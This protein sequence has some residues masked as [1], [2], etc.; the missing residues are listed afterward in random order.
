MVWHIAKRELY[1]NLNSLRFAVAIL[2][3]F[4][5]MLTNAVVHLREHPARVQRYHDA[6]RKA[7]DGVTG[8][9][10]SGLYE[11]ARKGP[12][13]FN[14][15]PAPLRFCAEGGER[16]FATH[17]ESAYSRWGW[18]EGGLESFWIVT[19]PSATPTMRSVRTAVT[20]VDWGFIIG[21]VLSLLALLFTFDAIAGERESGTLR[22]MLANPVPRHA[23]LI[24][25]FLGALISIGI[26][27]TLAVFVNLLVLSTSSDIHLGLEA[28]Q[29]L[30]IIFGVALLYVSLFLA[31]GLLV[32]ARV[33]SSAISLVILLLIWSVLVVFM[34]STLA[35]VAG[36][37]PP[38]KAAAGFSK[39]SWDHH[40]AL[41][42]EYES[43][44]AGLPEDSPRK[45]Q[46]MG[47]FVME[48]AAQQERLHAARLIER[49]SQVLRARNV[50]RFSPVATVQYLLESFA[51]TGFARH[52]QFLENVQS[53]AEQFRTFIVDTEHAD[54]E[55][56]HAIGVDAGMSGKL[57]SPE[58][59]PRFEDRLSLSRDVDAAAVDLLL[60]TLSVMVLL[61]GALLLFIGVDV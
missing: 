9:A 2:L 45:I 47:E 36:G 31:L 48:D 4:G 13:R 29:R 53:H 42:Q 30:G 61:A 1:D 14:K 41:E 25:K 40:D 7:T 32:S 15:R 57:V 55:S 8:R 52:L 22:L 10:K 46:L 27:F 12:G 49:I 50:T 34:P 59:V 60:L 37:A 39:R 18:G 43:L 23:L 56:L 21:Y 38:S 16:F 58:A 5:L 44:W 11:L 51:G 35:A 24:G 26:P 6:V 54:P 20:A 19:Y 17:A 33:R 3:L 28:W